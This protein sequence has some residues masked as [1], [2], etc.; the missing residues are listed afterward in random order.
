MLLTPAEILAQKVKNLS[1]CED[2]KIE[3]KHLDCILEE[4]YLYQ[5]GTLVYQEFYGAREWTE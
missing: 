3:T 4:R 2:E 1:I 5:E